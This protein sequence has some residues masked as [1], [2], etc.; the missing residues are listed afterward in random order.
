MFTID[1]FRAQY[2]RNAAALAKDV[3]LA[4]RVTDSGKG[5]AKGKRYRGYFFHQW[6]GMFVGAV[7]SSNASDEELAPTHAMLSRAL[8]K[9]ANG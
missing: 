6:V 4:R 2:I 3:E 8:S 7:M 9:S 5:G 1:Q